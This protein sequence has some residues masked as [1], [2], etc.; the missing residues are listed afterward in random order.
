IFRKVDDWYEIAA[1]PDS[2]V[3]VA[4]HLMTNSRTGREVNLRAGPGNEYNEYRTEPAGVELEIIKGENHKGW[5]KIKPPAD[6]KAW[7]SSRFVIVNDYELKELQASELKRDL[8]LIDQETGDF[9]GFL[10]DKDAK[11][12]F[13]LPFIKGADQEVSLKGQIVPLKSGA[14]YVTHALIGIS[15]R[16]DI[17][18][19][20]YLHC[21]NASLDIW[22]EKPVYIT[23][24]QKLVR[25]WKLPVIEI[26]T[27]VPE[28]QNTEKDK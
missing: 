16:A 14:V 5:F 3:W 21:K 9:A 1:P 22:R 28:N 15:G 20:A 24:T 2:S 11:P 10:K 6:L 18:T 7:V 19:I 12:A 27:V 13:I 17:S 26:K 23:G 8:V 4:G 25:G